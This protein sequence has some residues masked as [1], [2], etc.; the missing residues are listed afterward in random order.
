MSRGP[1]AQPAW[2]AVFGPLQTR[3]RNCVDGA[4]QPLGVQ[5]ELED[6]LRLEQLGLRKPAGKLLGVV[7]GMDSVHLVADD[8]GGDVHRGPLPDGRGD[9]AG[10]D[11]VEHGRRLT[12]TVGQAADHAVEGAVPRARQPPEERAGPFEDGP[13]EMHA[14]EQ[15]SE[16]K[17]SRRQRPLEDRHLDDEPPHPV[18][19]LGSDH[20]AHVCAKGDT[21][22]DGL[23]DAQVV[24]E[25]GDVSPVGV[26]AMVGGPPRLL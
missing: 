11:P 8:E 3:S 17:G 4:R 26:D 13:G 21:P 22:D 12:G 5:S 18:R 16:G 15:G 19:V 24:E 2:R 25:T 9:G 20:Q 7:E 1:L 23:V 14:Q 6:G 10:Q